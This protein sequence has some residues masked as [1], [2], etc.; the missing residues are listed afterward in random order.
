MKAND[1][2][3]AS[4]ESLRA[5]VMW[6][7][8]SPVPVFA[9]HILD[10][11]GVRINAEND[12]FDRTYR[13]RGT[14]NGGSGTPD[15]PLPRFTLATIRRFPGVVA[16]LTA[17]P[18]ISKLVNTQMLAASAEVPDGIACPVLGNWLIEPTPLP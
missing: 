8:G 15:P 12:V 10:G 17:R 3:S 16:F 4:S 7:K 14:N 18:A 5:S 9:S 11:A 6:L 13:V 1:R 2:R